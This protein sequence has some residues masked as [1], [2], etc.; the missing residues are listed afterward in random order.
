MRPVQRKKHP[1]T[2]KQ[3]LVMILLTFFHYLGMFFYVF[4]FIFISHMALDNPIIPKKFTLFT[5]VILY[6]LFFAPL[7]NG[8]LHNVYINQGTIL[9]KILLWAHAFVVLLIIPF[10]ILLS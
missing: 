5:W 1:F 10:L 2:F 6:C 9:N 7:V 3:I 8:I 4:L